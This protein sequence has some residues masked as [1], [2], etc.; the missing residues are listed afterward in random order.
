MKWLSIFLEVAVII[1][2]H[3]TGKGKRDLA[4]ELEIAQGALKALTSKMTP[5]EK[6][7]AIADA[8]GNLKAVKGFKKRITNKLD[9]ARD[10]LARKF[11]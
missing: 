10:R 11:L 8:A 1:Y 2:N 6:I 5:E 9:K 3:V 7:R 4:Q